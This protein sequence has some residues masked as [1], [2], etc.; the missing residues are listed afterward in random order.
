MNKYEAKYFYTASLMNEALLKIL[1][2]KEYNFINV[3]EICEKAGVNRS[4][5]YLHYESI[6]D[7]LKETIDNIN[8]AFF[9]SFEEKLSKENI[10]KEH[11]MDDLL[12]EKFLKVYLEYIKKNQRILKLYKLIPHILD[13]NKNYDYLY[14]KIFKPIMD[15][16]NIPENEQ[17]YYMAFYIEGIMGI[18]YKWL[19]NNCDT[20]IES[21]IIIIRRAFLKDLW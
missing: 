9:A 13:A 14:N 2:E 20:D 16:Y 11:T 7:L 18:I 10:L 17:K 19:D 15:L 4:T 21:M 1:E 3:K 6:D 12:S 5:F 8:K